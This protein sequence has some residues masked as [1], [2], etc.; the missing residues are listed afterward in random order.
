MTS[1][2]SKVL[3]SLKNSLIDKNSITVDDINACIEKI[4]IIIKND[5]FMPEISLKELDEGIK[6]RLRKDIEM[7]YDIKMDDCT[8]LT[9]EEQRTKDSEWWNKKKNL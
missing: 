8:I 2:Y 4:N 7:L 5:L 9:G 1:D 3:E 6:I